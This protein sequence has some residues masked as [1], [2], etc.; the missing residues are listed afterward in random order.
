MSYE[1]NLAAAVVSEVIGSN[2]DKRLII[3]SHINHKGK[4]VL[5]KA[6]A[7]LLFIELYK[8][9][10][11]GTPNIPDDGVITPPILEG[12]Y[13]QGWGIF[14][15]IGSDGGDWQL[16]KVDDSELFKK[17]SDAWEFV[18]KQFLIGDK[19]A[20]AALNFLSKHCMEEFLRIKNHCEKVITKDGLYNPV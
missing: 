1:S 20:N 10:D 12:A 16:Q 6:E 14:N 11:I 18:Y 13:E 3:H 17:D 15:C 7:G 8:F 9:L 4:M 2:E 5:N 19:T